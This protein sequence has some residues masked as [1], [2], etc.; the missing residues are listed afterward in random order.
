M[1][2]KL[3]SFFS[4]SRLD[5][6]KYHESSSQISTIKT[7]EPT[8]SITDEPPEFLIDA[9][10]NFNRQFDE[11]QFLVG[12]KPDEDNYL[13]RAS[14]ANQKAK[15]AMKDKKF[16][17]SWWLLN[18]QKIL[19]M[20]HAQRAEFT[21]RQTTQLDS[22]VHA[23]MANVLRL[24]GKDINA[25]CHIIYQVAGDTRPITDSVTKKLRAYFNR[26]KLMNTGFDQVLNYAITS[27]ESPDFNEVQSKVSGWR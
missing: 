24:E 11:G 4:I 15:L 6:Q 10:Q 25:L 21:V 13:G 18:Q 1:F 20:A 12:G 26:A 22:S 7:K 17:I 5:Q 8:L 16:D 9:W 27:K 3:K 19:Y 14:V 23:D 2:S